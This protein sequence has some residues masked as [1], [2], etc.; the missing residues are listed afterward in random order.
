MVIALSCAAVFVLLQLFL[1]EPKGQ[2]A[3]T[4]PDGTV[5]LIDVG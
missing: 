4:L 3:E 2:I 5:Q 1:L